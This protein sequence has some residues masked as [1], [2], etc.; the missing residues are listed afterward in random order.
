MNHSNLDFTK[1]VF[2]HSGVASTKPL[3]ISG[4]IS[5]L[6]L[7]LTNYNFFDAD[8]STHSIPQTK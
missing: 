4:M 1:V 6:V 7:V 2:H 5:F 3:I 8:G